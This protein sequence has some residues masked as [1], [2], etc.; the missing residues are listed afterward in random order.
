MFLR[1]YF[2]FF[3]LSNM[4][5]VY[6]FLGLGYYFLNFNV[7]LLQTTLCKSINITVDFIIYFLSY[8][9]E[10]RPGFY[11]VRIQFRAYDLE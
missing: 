8:Q 9:T 11:S 6:K 3:L 2:I 4:Q 10:V 5:L 7:I 1:F